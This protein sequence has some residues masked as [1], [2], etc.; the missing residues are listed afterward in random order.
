MDDNI[1]KQCLKSLVILTGLTTDCIAL[2]FFT[3]TILLL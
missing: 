1:A 2:K 3:D